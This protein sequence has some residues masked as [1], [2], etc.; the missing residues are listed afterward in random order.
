MFA[1]VRTGGKQYRVRDGDRIA[2][3]LLDAEP[4]DE[5]T[6]DEVLLVGPDDG[7]E[8]GELAI[9]EPLVAG[10]SVTARVE[11]QGRGPRLQMIKYKNKTRQRTH[12]GHRQRLTQLAITAIVRE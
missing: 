6:L 3:E 4:G 2:V 1:I 12:R 8:A 10:A 9:G 7:D 11:A 5:V